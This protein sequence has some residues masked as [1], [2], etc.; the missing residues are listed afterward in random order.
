MRVHKISCLNEMK[1]NCFGLGLVSVMKFLSMKHCSITKLPSY[2]Y[3][4]YIVILHCD[5]NDHAPHKCSFFNSK[6]RELNF[7]TQ[8]GLPNHRYLHDIL[9]LLWLVNDNIALMLTTHEVLATVYVYNNTFSSVGI[10][11]YSSK[12]KFCLYKH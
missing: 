5:W 12:N 7:S 2:I 10:W 3:C 8:S 4:I 11:G 9:S 6:M 1:L